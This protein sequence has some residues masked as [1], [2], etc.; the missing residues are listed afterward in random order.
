MCCF[1]TTVRDVNGTFILVAP[2]GWSR[3]LVVYQNQ[4]I[5]PEE[6]TAGPAMF[7]APAMIL[8]FPVSSK[9]DSVELLDLSNETELFDRLSDCFPYFEWAAATS[10]TSSSG[11]GGGLAIQVVGSY[12]VSVAM[13]LADLDRVDGKTFSMP[14]QLGDVFRTHYGSGFG[15]IVAAFWNTA[16]MH[17][18]AY[19]HER[20]RRELFVPTRHFHS[21]D[22]EGT[23]PSL[24]FRF[25]GSKWAT[26]EG[27]ADFDHVIYSLNT[28]N[29]AGPSCRDIRRALKR[30]HV[31]WM[32]RMRLGIHRVFMYNVFGLPRFSQ[33][34][35]G[36][37]TDTKVSD[38]FSK[39]KV[40]LPRN[41]TLRCLQKRGAFANC[42]TVLKLGKSVKSAVIESTK[43]PPVPARSRGR[44]Y[45]E[46]VI[47]EL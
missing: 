1:T 41:A 5:L 30:E 7:P 36:V 23:E 22:D 39:L 4:V 24:T 38:A 35:G 15:F 32:Q 17:P 12:V 43:R 33:D 40:K 28:T 45:G 11:S 20:R 16:R 25:D 47:I 3:Q 34:F 44:S 42:D 19:V 2:V 14:S 21:G 26:G 10:S 6:T 37:R 13:S 18:L 27:G 46:D 29:Q 8:P 31:E 9:N